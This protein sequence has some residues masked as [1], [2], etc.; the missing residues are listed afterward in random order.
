[1]ELY[2]P[3]ETFHEEL[4]LFLDSHE[5]PALSLDGEASVEL[6]I[7][8]VDSLPDDGPYDEIVFENGTSEG[9]H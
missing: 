5:L 9:L 1:M 3:E 6:D 4:S 7:P 2:V 8:L